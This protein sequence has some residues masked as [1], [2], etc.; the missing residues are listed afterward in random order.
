MNPATHLHTAF[1]T[2]LRRIALL[3][4]TIVDA[5]AGPHDLKTLF[6]YPP[7][8]HCMYAL[9]HVDMY[10]GPCQLFHVVCKDN[11]PCIKHAVSS[12]VNC[13]CLN[14]KPSGHRK[15]PGHPKTIRTLFLQGAFSAGD[16]FLQGTFSARDVFYKGRGTLYQVKLTSLTSTCLF[17]WADFPWYGGGEWTPLPFPLVW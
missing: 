4:F 13:L 3:C 14:R 17:R 10:I 7:R 11:I 5:A 1:R 15:P 2:K 6:C 16:F 12:R 9:T 8:W